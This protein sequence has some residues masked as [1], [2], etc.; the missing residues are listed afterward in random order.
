MQRFAAWKRFERYLLAV[1]LHLNTGFSEQTAPTRKRSTMSAR[2]E[3][4]STGQREGAQTAWVQS[5][6]NS[7]RLIC[8]V[9]VRP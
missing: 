6:Q 5:R 4:R 8:I 2:G 1:R 3:Q 9:W 7:G